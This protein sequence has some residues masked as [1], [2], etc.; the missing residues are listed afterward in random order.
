MLHPLKAFDIRA[1]DDTI[2]WFSILE[3]TFS[4]KIVFKIW[5]DNDAL[6]RYR[7]F[8]VM[9]KLNAAQRIKTFLWLVL[10]EALLTNRAR[11]KKG[12]AS[13]DLCALYGVKSESLL[14]A[15]RHCEKA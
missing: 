1:N 9:W 7:L 15:L 8:R 3:G 4:L 12:L 6:I 10:N 14:Y 11:F 5:T 13:N 2:A